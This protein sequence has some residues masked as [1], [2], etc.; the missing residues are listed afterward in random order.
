M[1]VEETPVN[2]VES[3]MTDKIKNKI[4]NKIFDSSSSTAAVGGDQGPRLT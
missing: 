4:K 2:C 3:E 1:Y